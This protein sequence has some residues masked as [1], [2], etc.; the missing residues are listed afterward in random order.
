MNLVTADFETYYAKDYT[1]QKTEH[2]NLS[3]SEYIRD[4]RFY[5]Q[6]LSLKIN[7][8]PAQ[9][10]NHQ[11]IPEA[12]AQINWG[13][14]ELLA[15]QT[16]F[17]ALI[18]N[19]HYGII[20]AYRR[21]TLSMSRAI[22]QTAGDHDLDSLCK[23]LGLKGKIPKVLDKF[24]GI[25]ELTPE[26]FEELALYCDNDSEQTYLAY[27]LMLPKFT[28]E[29][30]DLINLTVQLYSEP[31]I[32][33]NATRAATARQE[34][35]NERARLVQESG[36]TEEQLR[37]RPQFAKALESIKI[38]VPTKLNPKGK[39]TFAL[40]KN[41][42]GFQDLRNI[43][44]PQ[45]HALLDARIACTSTNTIT[46][47]ERL[48]SIT[49]NG[50]LPLP[51][52]LNYWGAHTPRWSGGDK[53]NPQ[54]FKRG[55]EL[56]RSLE[57][58]DDH[59]LG[60][61]DSSQIEA[62]ML[63][64]LADNFPLLE[65]F[66]QKRDIYSEFAS[67]AYSRTINRKL[68]K[69]IDGIETFPDFIEG[70]VGKTCILGLGFQ[71][72]G[73]K[74]QATLAAGAMDGPRVFIERN[75]A[76]NLVYI[77]RTTNPAVPKLWDLLKKMLWVM[78]DPNGDVTYKCLRFTHERVWLPNGM[79]LYYPDLAVDHNHQFS[80]RVGT[81]RTHIYEGLLTENIVQSLARIVLA[82]HI[83]QIAKRFRIVLT[84]HDELVALLRSISAKADLE[85]I[86]NIMRTPPA[87]CPTLPL[88]AEGGF[89][90]EYS[91]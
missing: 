4:P 52:Y 73:K 39:T 6:C 75:K 76:D 64:W 32:R 8:T 63:A 54:N 80:Y 61:S 81:G 2:C 83:L 82:W 11:D 58:P 85:W 79:C 86:F 24:K 69:L 15:Q 28:Q 37:S 38:I 65:A 12:L 51:I 59:M 43:P 34:E 71:M 49:K 36:L 72:A 90:K 88:D 48:L 40:A 22:F 9:H 33:L 74:L 5:A 70:F 31:V 3:I 1:L 87:W 68:K 14:T 16:H 57:A 42:P 20:P 10:Y 45:L 91:K 78:V 66:R 55:S 23:R 77:Y 53:T 47:A 50:T 25:R 46:R 26:Q 27:Q 67:I 41:D 17:E 21:D 62:R 84:T 44:N 30:L 19:E 89:A 29:E 7:D 56:R 60:V 18:L 13:S 35:L